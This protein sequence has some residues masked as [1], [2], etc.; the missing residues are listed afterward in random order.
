M[1]RSTSTAA[2]GEMCQLLIGLRQAK[3]LTQA[4]F[5][6]RLGKQQAFVSNIE[7]GA[8][9]IDVVEFYAIVRALDADPMAVFHELTQLLPQQVTI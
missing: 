9:R 3:G 2:Y 8:R 6:H 1:T 5:A 7:T 4:K